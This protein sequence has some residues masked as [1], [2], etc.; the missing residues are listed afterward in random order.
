MILLSGAAGTLVG[1]RLADRIGR[2][3]ILV[4]CM[5]MLAPLIVLV[6]LSGPAVSFILLGL[7]GFFTIGNFSITVVLGQ[8]FLPGRIGIASG[9]TLG[10]AIGIGGVTA[11]LLGVLADHAGLTAVMLVIAA[12]AVPALLCA[13]AL[14]LERRRGVEA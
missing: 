1:G 4:G 12:L 5:A 6:L 13:L 14:P 7:V 2:R 9:V 11:A 10:A 8:E 3:P